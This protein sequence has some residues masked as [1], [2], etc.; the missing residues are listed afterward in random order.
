MTTA[1]SNSG[2]FGTEEKKIRPDEFARR[3]WSKRTFGTDV[4]VNL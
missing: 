3:Y 1:T 4:T 2:R